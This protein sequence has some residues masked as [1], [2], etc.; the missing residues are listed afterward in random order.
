MLLSLVAGFRMGVERLSPYSLLVEGFR[1]PEL[2][3]RW[4]LLPYMYAD[5]E[6]VRFSTRHPPCSSQDG[7]KPSTE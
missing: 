1:T 2:A 6:P 5:F 4:R 7:S 3:E